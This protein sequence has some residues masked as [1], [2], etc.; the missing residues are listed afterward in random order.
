MIFFHPKNRLSM[1]NIDIKLTFFFFFYATFTFSQEYKSISLFSDFKYEK[2]VGNEQAVPILELNEEKLQAIMKH[3][4]IL[5][6]IP[7]NAAKS[8]SIKLNRSEIIPESGLM[9]QTS[10]GQAFIAETGMTFIGEIE[11]NDM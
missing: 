1:K 10:S 8:Y 11:E 7:I 2:S 3:K 9:V 4:N 6:D 5:L